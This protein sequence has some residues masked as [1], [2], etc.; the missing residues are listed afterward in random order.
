MWKLIIKLLITRYIN[1]YEGSSFNTKICPV[2]G[3][4]HE[5]I[6]MNLTQIISKFQEIVLEGKSDNYYFIVQHC[7]IN[8][9]ELN[10]DEFD[11]ILHDSG[12]PDAVLNDLAF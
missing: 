4:I 3:Q 9:E 5:R 11:Q 10:R 1:P 6:R 2:E 8:G 12:Y 7:Y